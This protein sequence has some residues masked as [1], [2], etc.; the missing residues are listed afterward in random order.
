MAHKSHF[1]LFPVWS[2]SKIQEC[3]IL[4]KVVVV[5]GIIFVLVIPTNGIDGASTTT[6]GSAMT[7]AS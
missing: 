4:V 7:L 5:D 1:N 6:A 2:M 3:I